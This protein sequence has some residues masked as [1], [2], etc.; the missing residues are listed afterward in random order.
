LTF[1]DPANLIWL[2]HG[3][4][5]AGISIHV[6]MKRPATGVALAWLL[7]IALLPFVGPLLYF[8]IG[9][10]RISG[11]RSRGFQHLRQVYESD[12][13]QT[14]GDIAPEIDWSDLPP[15]ANGIHHLGLL[16]AGSSLTKD[17]AFELLS[18]TDEILDRITRDIDG[19]KTSILM[20]FYIWN[21][22]GKADEVLAALVRAAGRGVSCRVLIDALGA[23]PWWKTG[24][25]QR[26]REAGVELREA[27]PV[28]L[29]RSAVGRTDLRLHRKVVVIDQAIAWTGSMNLVDPAFFKQD[30]GVG[31]WV[32]AMVR[33]EGGVV[34][35]LAAVMVGDWS[36]ETGDK[37]LILT[38]R[39]QMVLTPA[40]TADALAGDG[41]NEEI[42][43]DAEG[44]GAAM[45]VVASGPGET[46]DGLLLM[47]LALVSAATSELVLTT[48]YFVPDESLLRALRAASGRG[49]K[50]SLI[51]PE[52]VDSLLSRYASRSYYDELLEMG[53]NVYLYKGGLLHTKSIT[54]DGALSMFGTVNLD[55]R[56]LWLN[57]EVALFVYDQDFARTLRRLQETYISDSQLL[58]RSSWSA[59]PFLER[60]VENVL[61]LSGPLL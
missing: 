47:L 14:D 35:S 29:L 38:P 37:P 21:A 10:R 60:F 20:E 26:L 11:R 1:L 59:R 2:T 61:R 49:V 4:V 36:L 41:G 5:I 28:G 31:E 58:E 23:R 34:T 50:V 25:P 48:P 53:V 15:S 46:G 8:L 27:L 18:G 7:L 42:K 30:A 16:T 9:N 44:P 40:T 57:Y 24:Q 52:R 54:A 22:G 51:L 6:I 13:D 55:M 32:D 33:L 43:P 3:A 17:N 39:R 12:A 19:A 56:S 45:Q